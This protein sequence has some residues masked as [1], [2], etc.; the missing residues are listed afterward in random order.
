MVPVDLSPIIFVVLVLAWAV[1]LIPKALSHHDEV[2]GDRLEQGHTDKVRI[3][4]RARRVTANVTGA[5]APAA[6]APEPAASAPEA[7]VAD[8]VVVETVETSM[9]VSSQDVPAR[10]AATTAAAPALPTR[11]SARR[12]ARNR[13]RVLSVLLATLL[14]V[15]GL[16]VGGVVP[17]WLVAVP[18]VLVVGFLALARVSVRRTQAARDAAGATRPTGRP[19]GRPQTS[20]PRDRAD[21]LPAPVVRDHESVVVVDDTEN[22]LEELTHDQPAERREE[23][24]SALSEAGSLWDPLPL[25]LPTYVNKARA[26]RTVRTIELTGITSSGHDAA[27]SAVAREAAE[28]VAADAAAESMATSRVVG[29]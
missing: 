27:D 10:R 5:S 14:L 26:R 7:V 16:A 4:T 19:A 24:E 2:A 3:L 1:Y 29:G 6:S 20:A 11:A 23:I 18:A 25:T 8:Q 15:G 22:A 13:R 21:S 12:A 17:V 28:Q 9:E